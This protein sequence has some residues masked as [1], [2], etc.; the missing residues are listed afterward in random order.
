MQKEGLH[1]RCDQTGAVQLMLNSENNGGLA[2]NHFGYGFPYAFKKKVWKEVKFPE[3]DWNEDGEF[4]L[5]ASSKIKVDG[6]QDTIGICL[7]ILHL[8]STSRCFP[9]HH[10]PSFLLQRLFPAL[11]Y[12]LRSLTIEIEEPSALQGLAAFPASFESTRGRCTICSKLHAT[13][14]C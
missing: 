2:D 9:Q 8:A 12:P 10:L 6:I 11:E 4:S 5:K 1:Y 14:S 13:G 3:I 7:H